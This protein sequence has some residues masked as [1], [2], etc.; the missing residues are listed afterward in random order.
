MGTPHRNL[1]RSTQIEIQVLINVN[2]FSV[3]TL[4]ILQSKKFFYIFK[5]LLQASSQHY[6]ISSVRNRHCKL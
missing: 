2:L 1:S 4:N 3:P 6:K 5:T